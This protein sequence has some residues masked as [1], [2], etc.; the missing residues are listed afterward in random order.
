MGP[1]APMLAIMGPL[2]SAGMQVMG[3]F[4]A[5]DAGKANAKN[6]QVET[7]ERVRRQGA[8]DLR[9]ESRARAVSAASGV[10]TQGTPS[11]FMS[12]LMEENKAEL[13]FLRQSGSSQASIAKGQGQQAFLGGL[14]GAAG[15]AA[16]AASGIGDAF[17][18]KQKNRQDDWLY[19]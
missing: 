17:G 16:G 7:D 15:T 10:T 18:G 9:Q 14:G 19:M 1:I 11:S 12:N 2:L 8:E 6:I 13:D 3:A 5:K 4:G